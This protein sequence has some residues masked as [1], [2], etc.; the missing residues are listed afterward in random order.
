M[1]RYLFFSSKSGPSS[2]SNFRELSQLRTVCS[3]HSD[4]EL[5][6]ILIN[7]ISTLKGMSIVVNY[8]SIKDMLGKQWKNVFIFGK[9]SHTKKEKSLHW[10]GLEPTILVSLCRSSDHYA[11]EALVGELSHPYIYKLGAK[12]F[13]P[14]L[15]PLGRFRL[16]TFW[17]SYLW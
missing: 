13:S 8:Q 10:T 9:L 6:K 3:I 16:S 7:S 17:Q 2:Y 4:A 12:C 14:I 5:D 11:N 15:S 1:I